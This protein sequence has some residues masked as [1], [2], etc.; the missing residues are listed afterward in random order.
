MKRNKF[1]LN[2]EKT[3]NNANTIVFNKDKNAIKIKYK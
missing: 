1:I 2:G 3:K